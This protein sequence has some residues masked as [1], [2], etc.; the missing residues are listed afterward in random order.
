MCQKQG[1]HLIK[2]ALDQPAEVRNALNFAKENGIMKMIA[3]VRGTLEGGKPT[4]Y[5][6]AGIVVAVGKGVKEYAIGDHVAAA[7]AGIAN[8]AEYV[9]VPV[10][11]GDAHAH[12]GMD[13][14]LG[15]YRDLRW[16][17]NAGRAHE[18]N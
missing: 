16:N 7:G 17:S 9:D 5:S 4:G 11:L 1:S 3:R 8:H 6:I 13:F 14:K 10:N 18:P 12:E 2:R 15:L